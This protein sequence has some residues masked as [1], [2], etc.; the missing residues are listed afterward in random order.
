QFVWIVGAATAAILGCALAAGLAR[1]RERRGLRYTLLAASVAMAAAFTWGHASGVPD[2]DVV[3]VFHFVEYGLITFLF[4][5]AW[6]PR[7]DASIVI[8]PFLAALTA[9]TIDEGLQWFVPVRVGELKDVLL[10]S[11]AIGCGLLFSLGVDPPPRFRPR[12]A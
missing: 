1:I 11:V 6:R 7:E 8:L 5:R 9:G 12:L 4:Y 2:V 3:E 10:N